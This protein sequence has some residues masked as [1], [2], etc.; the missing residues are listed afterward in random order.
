MKIKILDDR[1]HNEK[2]LP[3]YTTD[4]AA[5]L[6]LRA[7]ITSQVN[8]WAMQTLMVHTGIAVAIPVGHVGFLVPRSGLGASGLVLGNLVGVIDSDYR[9]EVCVVLWNRSSEGFLRIAPMDRIA[10]M[11]IVPVANGHI[12]FVSELDGTSRGAGGFGH[13][14][15]G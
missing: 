12:E 2:Y 8:L 1:L 6:D 15:I 7:C 3:R 9:G 11:V 14:G 10:Q 13:T 5:G 4:G